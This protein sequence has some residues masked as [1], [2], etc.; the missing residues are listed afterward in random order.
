MLH[1][2][3]YFRVTLLLLLISTL[4]LNGCGIGESTS[5]TQSDSNASH[6]EES[7]PDHSISILNKAGETTIIGE[8]KKIAVLNWQ[9]ADFL[10]A[11]DIKPYARTNFMGE[12]NL[13]YLEKDALEGVIDLGDKPNLEVLSQSNPDLIIG[14]ESRREIYDQ[15]T[16]I[17]PTILTNE[18]DD[19]RKSL[20]ELGS[21]L[22][23]TKEA[24]EWLAQY[25]QKAA[26]SKQ[27]LTSKIDPAETVLYMRVMPKVLRIYSSTQSL[28][29]T[30]SQDTG[31][32]YLPQTDSIQNFENISI[33]Q[34]PELNPDHIF[35][36][37]GRPVR[38]EDQEAK[39][40]YEELTQSSIWNNMKAM[41]KK[42]VYTVPHWIISDAPHIKEKSIDLVL[43]KL[44]VNE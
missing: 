3:K 30:L 4:F 34:L 35:I 28:G 32:Q 41:K 18:T 20:Q 1:I 8:P 36:Q 38:G 21:M 25:D 19:W 2:K 9:L 23:K 16:K 10:L 5:V 40:I 15:L 37:V 13:E 42:Q 17:A 44:G 11:L 12:T 39:K 31:L 43:E 14:W 26:A 24:E 6:S 7:A 29:A 33:E 27:M 22:G